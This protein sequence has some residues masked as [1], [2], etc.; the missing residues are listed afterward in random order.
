[1]AASAA[2]VT[3]SKNP[4]LENPNLINLFHRTKYPKPSVFF[5]ALIYTSL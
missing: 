1:V 5:S 4:R 3:T 2:A